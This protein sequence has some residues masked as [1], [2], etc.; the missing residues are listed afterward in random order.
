MWYTKFTFIEKHPGLAIPL[1]ANYFT[2]PYIQEEFVSLQHINSIY[3]A[4]QNPA[5]YPIPQQLQLPSE[6]IELLQFSNGGTIING[7]REFGY[8]SPETI[9]SFYISYGFHVWAPAFLPVALNG[10]GKFYAYDLREAD[11]TSVI[12]VSAGNIGY[13]TDCW[14]MLGHTLDEVLS[15]TTNIEEEL[16]RLYPA[17]QPSDQQKRKAAIHKALAQLKAEKENGSITLKVYLSQKR[18]LEDEI[19]HLNL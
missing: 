3:P 4:G 13:E 12:V 6:Y 15:R 5:T 17:V 1:P 14:A 16:D 11:S 7:E 8:F 18:E 10:G 9:R 19:K 2:K